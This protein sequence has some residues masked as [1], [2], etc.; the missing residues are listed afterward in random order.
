M[1]RS[2]GLKNNFSGRGFSQGKRKEVTGK[3]E[4][5]GKN[6]TDIRTILIFPVCM[7]MG[8]PSK[9]TKE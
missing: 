7:K 8:Y 2:F 4:K 3:R 1:D 9:K 5:T 6:L